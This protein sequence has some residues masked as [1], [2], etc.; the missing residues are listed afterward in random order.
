MEVI[1]ATLLDEEI[2]FFFFYDR[3]RL[4]SALETL[5][6]S[7]PVLCVLVA[8]RCRSAVPGSTQY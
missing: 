2:V 8:A 7:H 3:I 4:V 5:N 6:Q 1:N